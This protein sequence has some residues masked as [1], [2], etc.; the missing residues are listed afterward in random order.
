MP[1]YF[2]D[3]SALVKRYVAEKGSMWIGNLTDPIQANRLYIA[4]IAG[5]EVVAAL[6]RR[7]RQGSTPHPALMNAIANFRTDFDSRFNVVEISRS[8]VAAAMDFAERHGLRGYD[9]VQLA[10]ALQVHREYLAFGTN[11]TMVSADVELNT[12]ALI[13]GLPVENP[14][15][16][17]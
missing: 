16:R 12:A 13:E 14:E 5:V 15:L 4:G 7:A 1:A 2:L 10:A 8:L 17:P 3:S 9:A 11:C 6:A